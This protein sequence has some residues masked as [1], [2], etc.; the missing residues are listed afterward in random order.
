MPETS[1]LITTDPHMQT[2]QAEKESSYEFRKRRHPQWRDNY[3]LY[4]NTVI[5]NRLTQRQTVNVPLMKYA[6]GSLMKEINEPPQLYFKNLD[7]NDQKE[8]FYN[9]YWKEFG[10]RNK[11]NIKDTIDKKQAM[12]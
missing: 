7:N 2:L 5:P 4:R 1:N 10:K 12:L 9:E 11:L 8:V 6:L 3:T